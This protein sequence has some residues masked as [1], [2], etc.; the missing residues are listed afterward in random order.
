MS[1]IL[2]TTYVTV[3]IT[4]TQPI[5]E[6]LS[7]PNSKSTWFPLLFF[8]KWHRSVVFLS[9]ECLFLLSDK[10]S[11]G[12]YASFYSIL[13][14]VS[15]VLTDDVWIRQPKH[16]AVSNKSSI[17]G[18]IE[19]CSPDSK[20]KHFFHWSWKGSSQKVELPK[21]NS[22]Q[23]IIPWCKCDYLAVR[24]H[25]RKANENN[26]KLRPDWNKFGSDVRWKRTNSERRKHVDM[27][28]V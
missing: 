15:A 27:T 24:G 21:N 16:V 12:F 19:L 9:V 20:N 28:N 2:I 18:S 22:V 10:H 26:E 25:W 7:G 4:T 3:R 1:R 11:Y 6:R 17:Q 8:L 13:L 5:T 14:R 23:L